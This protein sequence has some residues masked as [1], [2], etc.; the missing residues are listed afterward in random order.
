MESLAGF[1]PG[2][3]RQPT[4][5]TCAASPDRL[6]WVAFVA[7]AG[8]AVLY[9][10]VSVSRIGLRAI[11]LPPVSILAMVFFWRGWCTERRRDFLWAGFW[12][13]LAMYTYS[14]ARFLPVV[15]ALFIAVEWLLW[16]V[17]RLQRQ[18]RRAA[19]ACV[20]CCGWSAAGT[21]VI[22]P[23]LVTLALQPGPVTP[24]AGG[25]VG[26]YGAG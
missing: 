25:G 20:V 21:L 16:G 22:L 12:F 6:Q 15:L 10:H 1:C 24:A 5:A 14:A 7:A 8:L 17:R 23:L 13:G 2:K 4:Q 18:T 26:L 19:C 3:V 9:W 11:L